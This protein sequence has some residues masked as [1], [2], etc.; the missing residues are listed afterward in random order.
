MVILRR[1]IFVIVSMRD[2]EENGIMAP[3][4]GLGERSHRALIHTFTAEVMTNTAAMRRKNAK[5]PRAS[6]QTAHITSPF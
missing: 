5:G 3:I 2:D 1:S 6:I 4:T